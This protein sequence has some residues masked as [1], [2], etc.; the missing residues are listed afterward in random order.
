ML[1]RAFY[2]FWALDCLAIPYL[3]ERPILSNNQEY[4]HECTRYG[5]PEVLQLK[6]MEKPTPS[7]NELCI[8]I[9]A[10]ALTASA[11]IVRSFRVPINLWLPMGL[12]LGFNKPRQPNLG[13]VFAGKVDSIGKDV[14]SVKS[15]LSEVLPRTTHSCYGLKQFLLWRRRSLR[16]IKRYSR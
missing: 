11:S 5:P 14:E 15:A 3:L 4:S 9:F 16:R 6:E 12:A 1:F 2:T 10:T 8:K 7:K 13:I